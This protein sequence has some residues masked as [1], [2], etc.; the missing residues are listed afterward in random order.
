MLH[1]VFGG[2]ILYLDEDEYVKG[3]EIK[4]IQIVICGNE[5]KNQEVE[6]SS[7]LYKHAGESNLGFELILFYGAR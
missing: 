2:P 1:T 3:W 7:S 5:S 4:T 6:N